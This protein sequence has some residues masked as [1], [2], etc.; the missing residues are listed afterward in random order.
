MRTSRRIL[1]PLGTLQAVRELPLSATDTAYAFAGGPSRWLKEP[2]VTALAVG[3]LHSI[4]HN[5]FIRSDHS[6]LRASSLIGKLNLSEMALDVKL[7][8]HFVRNNLDEVYLT[9]ISF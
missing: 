5:S 9:D 4:P 1:I 8:M 7:L 2:V 6:Y 3:F